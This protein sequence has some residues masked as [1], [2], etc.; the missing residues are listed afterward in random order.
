[1]K[2]SVALSFVNFIFNLLIWPEVFSIIFEC[3]FDLSLTKLGFKALRYKKVKT[4]KNRKTIKL[5]TRNFVKIE[6][7]LKK[8]VFIN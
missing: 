3:L 1:M 6:L 5:K 2:N 7:E 8:L 4:P